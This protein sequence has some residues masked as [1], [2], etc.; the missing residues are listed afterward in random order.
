MSN[1]LVYEKNDVGEVET[2]AMSWFKSAKSSILRPIS[3]RPDHHVWS[4]P[5]IAVA[6]P[7]AAESGAEAGA[8]RCRKP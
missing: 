7:E 6:K 2:L 3:T 8:A 5:R 4:R 1:D